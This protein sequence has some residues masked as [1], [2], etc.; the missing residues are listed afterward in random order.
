L[1]RFSLAKKFFGF[2]LRALMKRSSPKAF[3]CLSAMIPSASFGA[4]MGM[5]ESMNGSESKNLSR[6]PID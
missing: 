2:T 6:E 4:Q 1:R 3:Y 5:P